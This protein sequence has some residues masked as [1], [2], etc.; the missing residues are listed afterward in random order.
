MNLRYQDSANGGLIS[1]KEDDS[2]IID[3]N[4]QKQ[5]AN[6]DNLAEDNSISSIQY[7]K[8]CAKFKNPQ[9]SD[10]DDQHARN[11]PRI[12]RRERQRKSTPINTDRQPDDSNEVNDAKD[13][14]LV[15]Q[16]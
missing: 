8:S 14:V 9:I 15:T 10:P 1:S 7:E 4:S 11:K 13:P 12:S 5:V 6:T 3:K 2:L 16:D